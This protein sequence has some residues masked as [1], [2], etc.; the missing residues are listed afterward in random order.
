MEGVL[1]SPAPRMD[2]SILKDDLAFLLEKGVGLS[3]T[4][5]NLS[6]QDG[7]AQRRLNHR[8]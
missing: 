2:H 1:G 5:V 4:V 8:S 6:T 3:L 7:L